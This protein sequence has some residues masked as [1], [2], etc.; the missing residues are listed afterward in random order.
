MDSG[1]GAN[2]QDF[3]QLW[4]GFCRGDR[5]AQER[6]LT[7]FYQELRAVARR[8]LAGDAARDHLQPTELVNE[9]LL[10]LLRINRVELKDRNH[11]MALSARMMR[12]VLLDEV[13]RHRAQKRQAPPVLTTWVE[14]ASEDGPDDGP[15]DI[16]ALDH[17]LTRLAEVSADRARIVELRFFAGMSVEDI[18]TLMNTSERTVKRHWQAARAWLLRDLTRAGAVGPR[19]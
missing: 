19:L 4:A 3:T 12:Q 5:G 7:A 8:L 15:V 10:R 9:T 2:P 13:R 17:A 6:L 16:E 14:P 18:A 1:L 11:F